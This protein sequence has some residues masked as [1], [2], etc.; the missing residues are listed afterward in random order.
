MTSVL[1]TVGNTLPGAYL[2]IRTTTYR[3]RT[4]CRSK[5]PL[6]L[7]L[8]FNTQ[9]I[10]YLTDTAADQGAFQC[11]PGFHR[12][13]EAWLQNLPADADPR[14]QDL[15]AEAKPIAGRAGDL[16][17]WHHQLPHGSSPNRT[18]RPRVVQYLN[19]RPSQWD[20]NPVWK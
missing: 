4:R 16:I 15:S 12:Q 7:P 14:R 8:N 5:L 10:L 11:V 2:P 1:P 9:A 3:V 6:A 20:Y 17:I 13:L 18:A 19:L